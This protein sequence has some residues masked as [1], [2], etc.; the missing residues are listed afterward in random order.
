MDRLIM[1]P[2]TRSNKN[3]IIIL[4]NFQVFKNRC[5]IIVTDDR[6]S[7]PPKKNVGFE[8]EVLEDLLSFKNR[9]KVL[10]R[11]DNET[12]AELRSEVEKLKDEISGIVSARTQQR[13]PQLTYESKKHSQRN[14]KNAIEIDDQEI[15][16]PLVNLKAISVSTAPKHNLAALY[17]GIIKLQVKV[18]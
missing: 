3:Q 10:K 2:V 12:V 13:S 4:N 7:T 18:Y 14:N 8:D 9:E 1:Y 16:T 11:E 15:K 17:P 6:F 5:L